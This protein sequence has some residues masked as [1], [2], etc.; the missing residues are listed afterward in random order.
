MNELYLADNLT[1]GSCTY[2]LEELAFTRS[3]DKVPKLLQY[4]VC[5]HIAVDLFCFLQGNSCNIGVIARD[6]AYLP[7][8]REQLTE[9]VVSNYFAHAFEVKS[10]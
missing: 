5:V 2:K 10:R 1:R 3:G 6:P 7:Y 9:E 8:I 4:Y